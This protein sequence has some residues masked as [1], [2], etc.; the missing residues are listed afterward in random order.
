LKGLTEELRG[1]QL[2]IMLGIP[3]GLTIETIPTRCVDREASP[4]AADVEHAL[5]RL[6]LQLSAYEPLGTDECD[7][8][9]EACVEPAGPVSQGL[10]V[11]LGE[12]LRVL[13]DE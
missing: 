10:G 11:V 4:A 3:F 1:S 12:A 5:T 9:V 2:P 7:R 8:L 6:E 13:G